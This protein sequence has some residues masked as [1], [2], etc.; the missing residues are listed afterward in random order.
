MEEDV[1]KLG[2]A[3]GASVAA[4]LVDGLVIEAEV[5]FK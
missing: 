3:E 4:C 2:I 1:V 5:E